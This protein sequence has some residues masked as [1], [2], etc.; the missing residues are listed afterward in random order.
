MLGVGMAVAARQALRRRSLLDLSG[1]TALVTGG[2]RG[3]G[4]ALAEELSGHGCRL[5][6]CARGAEAL[7]RARARLAA[8]GA[9]VLAVQC[10]VSDREQVRRMVA[11]ATSQ[12]GAI[13]I[14][15]NNAGIIQSGPLATQTLADVE[16]ALR[17]MFWGSV[18]PTFEVL[19]AM[20]QRRAGRIVFITSIGGKVAVPHLLSY[21][22][23]KF[24]AVGF[25]EGLRAELARDG[26]GVLTVV[27]GLMRTG[28]HVHALFK[29]QHRLEYALFAPLASLPFTSL[30]AEDAARDIVAALRRN[31]AELI[32]GWQANLLARVHGLAPGLTSDVLGLINRALPG[33][34]GIGQG[35]APGDASRSAISE[36]PLT[37]MGEDAARRLNQYA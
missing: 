4:L 23:A 9:S 13:D 10:D 30:A 7:E 33:G 24:A 34:G 1:K 36:T 19:P 31:D 17:V 21:S 32:L 16:E 22:A 6:L 14:L 11:Q 2:S 29:G 12:F 8:G 28:G 35:H 15:V 5:V 27:P 25:A 26:V 20:R 3:L 18:Y 37:A